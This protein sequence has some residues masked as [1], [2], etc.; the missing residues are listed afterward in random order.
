MLCHT[1]YSV[2]NLTYQGYYFRVK[3]RRQFAPGPLTKC[4]RIYLEY[5]HHSDRG[6]CKLGSWDSQLMWPPVALLNSILKGKRLQL[7]LMIEI[8]SL[9]N[10]PNTYEMFFSN[11][12]YQSCAQHSC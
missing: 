7:V 4:V 8:Q 10:L 2:N 1:P 3:F 12:F 11:H 6:I 9:Y 5:G